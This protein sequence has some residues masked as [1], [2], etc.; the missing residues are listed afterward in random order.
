MRGAKKSVGVVSNESTTC[1]VLRITVQVDQLE[2]AYIM[3]GALIVDI[4]VK[5]R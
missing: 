5:V 3:L 1:K 4:D 2:K